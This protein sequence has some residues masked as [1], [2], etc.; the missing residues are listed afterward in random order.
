MKHILQSILEESFDCFPYSGRSMYGKK[1]LAITV[2]DNN[3]FK[4]M[5][6][7][8]IAVADNPEYIYK[9]ETIFDDVRWDSLGLDYVVY[10]PRV[11]YSDEEEIDE[12][13]EDETEE[14]SE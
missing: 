14:E 8:L 2:Q 12:E 13:S 9:L 1:C 3:L 6:D 7:I 5:Q 11:T 4:F 10:F